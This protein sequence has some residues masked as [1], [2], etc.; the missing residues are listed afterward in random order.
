[1]IP[2][3]ATAASR[4]TNVFC[5]VSPSSGQQPPIVD[6]R[7]AHA[8]GGSARIAA[9]H[10]IR[11]VTPPFVAPV[12][13]HR[14]SPGWLTPRARRRRL[15]CPG[16]SLPLGLAAAAPPPAGH[17]GSPLLPGST[18]GDAVRG[19]LLSDVC[20][21]MQGQRALVVLEVEWRS[22]PLRFAKCAV[23]CG[24]DRDSAPLNLHCHRQAG[25]R[26]GVDQAQRDPFLDP[27]RLR[28]ARR[29]GPA[30]ECTLC[31]HLWAPSAYGFSRWAS[32]VFRV[33]TRPLRA[34]RHYC[35]LPPRP[36]WHLG[37]SG[38]SAAGRYEPG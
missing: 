19:I 7:T 14:E 35:C 9:E 12:I 16:L 1:V 10:P 8:G 25:P 37:S 38:G 15:H 24:Q 29:L 34:A 32:L 27:E 36:T 5:P 2:V 11:R 17:G 13:H 30:T 20:P 26:L 28:P 31:R 4:A 22:R 33:P 23:P 3:R 21:D 6:R 18:Q